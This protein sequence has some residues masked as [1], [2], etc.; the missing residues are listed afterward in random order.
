MN[1]EVDEIEEIKRM[2]RHIHNEVANVRMQQETLERKMDAIVY[3]I[4][5]YFHIPEKEYEKAIYLDPAS[6]S[7]LEELYSP[8][9][10]VDR[11]SWEEHIRKEKEQTPFQRKEDV[12]LEE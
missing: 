8:I 7:P 11:I 9:D 4:A 10:E 3:L 6:H 12:L 5:D 1:E 2:L